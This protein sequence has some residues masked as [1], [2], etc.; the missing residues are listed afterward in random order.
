MRRI[1]SFLFRVFGLFLFFLFSC[2]LKVNSQL[3]WNFKIGGM[4]VSSYADMD[5]A[6]G[7]SEK[8]TTL[9]WFVELGIEKAINVSENSFIFETGLRYLNKSVYAVEPVFTEVLYSQRGNIL[10]LPI[11]IGYEKALSEKFSVRASVGPYFSYLLGSPID[12]DKNNNLHVGIE[13]SVALYYKNFNIGLQYNLPIYKGYKNENPNTIMLTLG[14]RFKGKDWKYVGAGLA[15][16]GAAAMAVG[17]LAQSS[18]DAVDAIV[19]PKSTSTQQK[20]NERVLSSNNNSE[21]KSVLTMSESRH[22]DALL[23]GYKDCRNR[24]VDIYKHMAKYSKYSVKEKRE[25]VRKN[26]K[27]MKEYRRKYIE[28]TGKELPISDDFYEDWNPTDKELSE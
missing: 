19:E 8:E 25:V 7:F 17:E 6:Q 26:Q 12:Y 10:E 24:V 5:L 1:N 23:K 28:L 14:I 15:T 27:D 18:S 16:V 9:N 11:K 22:A 3:L 20:S 4:P 13:P 2:S 21:N